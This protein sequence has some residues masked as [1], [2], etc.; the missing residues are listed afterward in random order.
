MTHDSN[1]R[2]PGENDGR[3]R[4]LTLAN[5][6]GLSSLHCYHFNKGPSLFCCRYKRHSKKVEG[7]PATTLKCSLSFREYVA[8]LILRGNEKGE[9]SMGSAGKRCEIDMR[10]Y[11]NMFSLC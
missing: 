3:T 6:I 2:L 11:S 4:L 1:K 10:V 7:G 5:S 8:P 9:I